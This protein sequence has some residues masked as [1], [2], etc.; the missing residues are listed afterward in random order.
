MTAADN[1][2]AIGYNGLDDYLY[3]IA[4]PSRQLVR[5]SS[6]GAATAVATFTEAQ[7]GATANVGD[8]DADGH[9]WFGSAG[10]SWHEVDLVPESPTV[11]YCPIT[12]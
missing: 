11:S 6:A 8:V 9:F 1:V 7:M 4:N 3:G 12:A 10:T 2:N 5:V